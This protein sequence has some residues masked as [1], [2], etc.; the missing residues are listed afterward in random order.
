MAED[1]SDSLSTVPSH[2]NLLPAIA[3]SSDNLGGRQMSEVSSADDSDS[4]L[5]TSPVNIRSL[6]ASTCTCTSDVP[7]AEFSGETDGDSRAQGMLCRSPDTSTPTGEQPG[8][9]SLSKPLQDMKLDSAPP[10]R[11][12]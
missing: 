5:S 11:V 6:P 4:L 1:E 12:C 10:Y 2:A 3:A 8:D 9:I 7:L